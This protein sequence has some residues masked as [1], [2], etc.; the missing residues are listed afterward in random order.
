MRKC[1]TGKSEQY[2]EWGTPANKQGPDAR[3]ESDG[4]VAYNGKV[5]SPVAVPPC[6]IHVIMC[7]YTAANNHINKGCKY[8]SNSIVNKETGSQ[9][10]V[11][12]KGDIDLSKTG[13][14]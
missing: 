3:G 1:W 2:T 8:I 7:T 5:A 4:C 13:S 6:V 14:R 9:H 12:N 10:E 11:R